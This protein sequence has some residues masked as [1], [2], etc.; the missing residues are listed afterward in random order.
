[1]LVHLQPH[2]RTHSTLGGDPTHTYIVE[3]NASISTQVG[4]WTVQISGI[5]FTSNG[6]YVCGYVE[7]SQELMQVLENYRTTTGTAFSNAQSLA[8]AMKTIEDGLLQTRF[9]SPAS[10]PRLFWQMNAG[11]PSIPYDGVP[12]MSVGHGTELPCVR[13]GGRRKKVDQYTLPTGDVIPVDIRFKTGCEAKIT[14]RRIL[15]YPSAEYT[16]IGVQGIA[17]VRRTRKQLLDDLV[18]KIITGVA[19]PS[20][21]YYFL[22][23]TPMAHG[24]HAIP[25]IEGA[26]PIAQ[27]V[28]EEIINQLSNGVTDIAVLRDHV[29]NYV[30]SSYGTEVTLHV[31]DPTYFPSNFDIFRHVYWLYKAGQ[32]I[33]Q[34]SALK[35]TIGGLSTMDQN[36][37]QSVSS[38]NATHTSKPSVTSASESITSVY[39]I[40]M[41]D[42][43]GPDGTSTLDHLGENPMRADQEVELN[44]GDT[45]H[46]V[47]IANQISMSS[48]IA[49][50]SSLPASHLAHLV[51]RSVSSVA[52]GPKVMTP[53]SRGIATTSR[54]VTSDY[55]STCTPHAEVCIMYC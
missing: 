48:P 35:A 26:L 47:S 9:M 44:S 29:K 27:T 28:S 22:L 37:V 12:F 31:N 6:K 32:V 16:D 11:E 51:K 33:D 24:G 10:R 54:S 14:I 13:F 34:E 39:S 5:R 4:D 55:N 3:Q 50:P 15:R 49:V 30:N 36:L 1:M 43:S 19:K 25:E 7:S 46:E 21:R 17:A 2:T 23:P 52:G 38:S 41:D 18:Q 8:N 53:L 20:E 45:S 40:I 42:G